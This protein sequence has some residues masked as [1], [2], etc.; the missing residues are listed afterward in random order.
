[1]LAIRLVWLVSFRFW[2]GFEFCGD[3]FVGLVG[4]YGCFVVMICG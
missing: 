3:R 1:M 4:G 2:G